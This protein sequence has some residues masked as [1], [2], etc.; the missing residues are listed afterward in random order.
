MTP[1]EAFAVQSKNCAALG[2]PFMGRLM[3]L[4]ADRLERGNPITDRILD[5]PGDPAPSADNVSLRFAGALHALVLRGAPLAALYPPNKVDDDT[6]W[7]GIL[8]AIAAHQTEI[9]RFL[10]KAPQTNE[11]RRSAGLLAAVAWLRPRHALILSEV[12]A[13][14]GLNLNVAF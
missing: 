2:S 3:Q 9:L 8:D 6:L 10:D 11:V 13:S 12:G 14:A 5:W 4:C 1:R 7:R